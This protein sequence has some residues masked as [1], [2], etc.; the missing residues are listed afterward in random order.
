M[1][2]AISLIYKVLI[3]I[4]CSLVFVALLNIFE[5]Y[6]QGNSRLLMNNK[7]HILIV[8]DQKDAYNRTTCRL[9]DMRT[10]NVEQSY[11]EKVHE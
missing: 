11:K 6:E 5:Q 1:M 8:C 10:D 2:Q 3:V 7:D 9:V 4:M